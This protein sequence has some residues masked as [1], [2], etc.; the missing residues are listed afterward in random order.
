LPVAVLVCNPVPALCPQPTVANITH[1]SI[2]LVLCTTTLH[3]YHP[4]CQHHHQDLFPSAPAAQ[5]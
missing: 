5:P 3:H 2:G 4:S 1:L